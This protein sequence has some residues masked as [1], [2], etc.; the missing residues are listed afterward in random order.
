[1]TNLERAAKKYSM[2]NAAKDVSIEEAF[3]EGADW[4][5]EQIFEYI[6]NEH[7]TF[8]ASFSSEIKKYLEE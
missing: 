2:E 4:A 8:Y 3:E 7:P 1:M 5:I 6:E